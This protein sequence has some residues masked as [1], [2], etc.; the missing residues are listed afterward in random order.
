MVLKLLDRVGGKHAAPG[1]VNLKHLLRSIDS[2]AHG[3]GD[4]LRR[5]AGLA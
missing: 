3:F 5:G 1:H 4:F 2:P